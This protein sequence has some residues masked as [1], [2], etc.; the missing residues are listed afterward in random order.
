MV[1]SAG[2]AAVCYA[3]TRSAPAGVVFFVVGVLMDVDHLID[4]LRLFRFRPLSSSVFRDMAAHMT[5]GQRI[6]LV[7]H[8]Y[9]V[10]AL[11]WLVLA[12]V[13]FPF[14]GAILGSSVLL[15][16]V[17]DQCTNEVTPFAY[18]LSYRIVKRF[19]VEHIFPR[20][21]RSSP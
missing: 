20:S 7:L 6:Y 5:S 16:L 11:V 2:G 17:L 3:A 1:A 13:G 8:G 9:E 15:H 4:Y 12:A 21:T 14:I 18:F 10:V 19:R